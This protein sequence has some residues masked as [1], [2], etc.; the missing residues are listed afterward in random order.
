M[1]SS[2]LGRDGAGG[3]GRT[4]ERRE[5][6]EALAHTLGREGVRGSQVAEPPVAG[7]GAHQAHRRHAQHDE[8]DEQFDQREC[9]T[10]AEPIH[11]AQCASQPSGEH[12]RHSAR[13]NESAR[14]RGAVSALLGRADR[15]GSVGEVTQKPRGPGEIV[16]PAQ[17]RL[18]S[19]C[20]YWQIG[21]PSVVALPPSVIE[22]V[23]E[24]P[25]LEA[26]AVQPVVVTAD[27]VT[28]TP[29]DDA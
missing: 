15:T 6:L 4:R 12:H 8:R 23:F 7:E 21:S 22:Q 24:V 5:L 28:V 1:L 18:R 3:S 26:V 25:V 13:R 20:D 19:E 14:G 11:A 10:C 29:G 27:N 2:P 17:I 9:V 16:R